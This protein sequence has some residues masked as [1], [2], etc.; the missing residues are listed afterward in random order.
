[1]YPGHTLVQVP[2]HVSHVLVPVQVQVPVP[3]RYMSVPFSTA[4]HVVLGTGT[5]TSLK[6][7]YVLGIPT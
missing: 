4:V 2:V 6:L 3:V 7:L 5:C 1:M